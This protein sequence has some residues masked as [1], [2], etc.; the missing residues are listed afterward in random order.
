MP[1]PSPGREEARGSP[2]D[3]LLHASKMPVSDSF[4]E[5]LVVDTLVTMGG[6]PSQASDDPAVQAIDVS[7]RGLKGGAATDTNPFGLSKEQLV[8]AE[9]LDEL[10]LLIIIINRNK[11][12]NSNN[13]SNNSA[14]DDDDANDLLRT[15][16]SLIGPEID[17]EE[18]NAR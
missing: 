18:R 13:N 6:G 9:K 11:N 15:I 4:S 1:P 14:C 17:V 8:Q 2:K 10:L 5:W 7:Q 3:A 12:N 16:C